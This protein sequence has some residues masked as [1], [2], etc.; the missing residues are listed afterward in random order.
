M[1]R[2]SGAAQGN[3]DMFCC[4]KDSLRVQQVTNWFSLCTSRPVHIS[5][6]SGLTNTI[7]SNLLTLL[8][9]GDKTMCPLPR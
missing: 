8:K 1:S 5:T 7:A 4:C 6:T 2:L 3:L 9:T